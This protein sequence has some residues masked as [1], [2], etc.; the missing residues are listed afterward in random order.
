[1]PWSPCLLLCEPFVNCSLDT[2]LVGQMG[3]MGE[4][5]TFIPKS[6]QARPCAVDGQPVSR[7]PSREFR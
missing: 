4:V 3:Y 5:S 7:G 2:R 6:A 1:M